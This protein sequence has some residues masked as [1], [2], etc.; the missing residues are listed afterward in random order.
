MSATVSAATGRTYGL[1]RVCRTWEVARSTVYAR[2]ARAAAPPPTTPAKRRGPAPIVSDADLLA[3]IRADLARS[4]FSGEGH[5]KVWARLTT[6]DKVPVAR[7]RV[8]RVMRENH[9]LSPHRVRQGDPVTH[10]GRITTDE[11]NE[12]WGTDGVR[13]ETVEQGWV[14][15]FAAV[16]HWNAECVGWHVAKVGSRYAALEPIAMGLK[17]IYGSIEGATARG[18]SLR[19]DYGTQYTSE[20]FR[21]QVRWWGIQMSYAFVAEPQTNG[22][23][24]RFNRT[25]KEQ[26]IH[27][28][29]FRNIEELRAAV[30][31]FVEVYNNEWLI[32]KRGFVS[33]RRARELH[34]LR[35]VA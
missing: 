33:P 11:P 2:R 4:P 5:R 16:E 25:L 28:R 14:W 15:I 35:R 12:M 23:A 34:A 1:E 18:L 32:E 21:E 8:L 20:A 3:L 13:V 22:V 30:G 10:D 7:K 27:G 17:N 6:M 29:V 31:A 24:E 26:V 19:S 9:L